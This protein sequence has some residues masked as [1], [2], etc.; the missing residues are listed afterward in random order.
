MASS[1]IPSSDPVLIEWANRRA[2]LFET[3]RVILGLS[4]LQLTAYKS[5]NVSMQSAWDSYQKA[6]AAET[7]ARAIFTAAKAAFKTTATGDI[8]TIRQTAAASATPSTV[9]AA[10][11]IPAPKTPT[12][13]VLPGQPN[14]VKATLDTV[15]GNLR[16]TW[17]CNNPGTVSGTVYTIQRRV[18]VS[19]TFTQV[20]IVGA[21][22]FLDSTV[23]SAPIVQY[24][25]TAQR[26]ELVGNPSGPVTVA[27]GHNSTGETFVA[28]VSTGPSRLAA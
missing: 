12:S 7:D 21:R 15:T 4:T 3:N 24:Q 6:K 13:G 26:G 23:P 17:K 22:N 28:S 9:Y 25:I 8:T 11:E 18:G 27:F 16:L 20:G 2:D 10:G 1:V 14:T 19:G 5:A